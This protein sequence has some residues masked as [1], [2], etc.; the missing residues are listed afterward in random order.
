MEDELR[1]VIEEALRDDDVVGAFLKGSH[2]QGTADQASDYDVVLIVRE[3]PPS[4][5]KAGKVDVSRATLRGLRDPP[6]WEL[7]ALAH[8]RVLFDKTGDLAEAIARARRVDADELAEL[9]DSYLNFFYRSLKAWSRGNELAARV[10][11]SESVLYLAQFLFALDGC[12]APYPE[13]WASGLPAFAEDLLEIARTGDPRR[14]QQLQAR[15]E[16]IARERGLD[17]VYAGWT[18]GEIERAMSLSFS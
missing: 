9:L 11:A 16:R 10:Q 18:G 13:A 15:V 14:Q 3:G 5:E 4:Q 6:T 17:R 1:P 12:R 2:S 7:P 8:A